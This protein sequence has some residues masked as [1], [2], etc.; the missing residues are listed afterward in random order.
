MFGPYSEILLCFWF[1]TGSWF[2]QAL[3]YVLQREGRDRDFLSCLT[4][5]ARRV[6]FE[7]QSNTPGDYVMHEKKQI[8]CVTSMLTRDIIFARK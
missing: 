1:I 7:F 6:A 4:M 8:P 2:I 5:V 3:C